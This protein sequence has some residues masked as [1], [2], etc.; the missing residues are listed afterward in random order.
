MLARR[1]TEE[2][3]ELPPAGERTDIGERRRERGGGDRPDA[4]YRHQPPRRII[5]LGE[6]LK[7]GVDGGK[8][9]VERID[10][11]DERRQCRPYAA[12]NDRERRQ[13]ND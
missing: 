11:G 6:L 5:G 1:Q 3:G 13:Y 8:L 2:G 10:L 7:L 12:K 4:W 9:P